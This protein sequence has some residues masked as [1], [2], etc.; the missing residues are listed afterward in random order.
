M[1]P[2]SLQDALSAL[3]FG[4]KTDP[5]AVMAWAYKLTHDNPKDA[6]T[7]AAILAHIFTI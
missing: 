3:R 5:A 7:I 4:A 6:P 2:C 1:N